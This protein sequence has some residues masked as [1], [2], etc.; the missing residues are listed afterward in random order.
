ME[1]YYKTVVFISFGN[2]LRNDTVDDKSLG[3]NCLHVMS[4]LTASGVLLNN[5]H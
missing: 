5:I 4:H 2:V 3:I 1:N